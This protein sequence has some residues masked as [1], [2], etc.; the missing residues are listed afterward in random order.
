MIAGCLNGGHGTTPGASTP[1]AT[2]EENDQAHATDQDGGDDA[3][4]GLPSCGI[5]GL[6]LD[7]EQALEDAFSG[8]PNLQADGESDAP[9]AEPSDDATDVDY[10]A[11]ESRHSQEVAAAGLDDLFRPADCPCFEDSD[12]TSCDEDADLSGGGLMP[13]SIYVPGILHVMHNTALD[14]TKKMA[15][16]PQF[17]VQLKNAEALLSNTGR[18][19]VV[20]EKCI[21]GSPIR[22][23]SWLVSRPCS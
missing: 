21:K 20:L 6:R 5:H 7:G 19:R 18:M 11:S 10:K 4:V 13:G 15:W 16:W 12:E 1:A 17:W 22:A 14:M 3:A 8:M 23:Y 2:D 9:G